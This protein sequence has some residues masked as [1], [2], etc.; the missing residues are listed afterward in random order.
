[1]YKVVYYMTAGTLTSKLF[2][3][4]SEAL[5]FSVYSVKSGNV[6]EIYKVD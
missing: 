4:L 1:M 2:D 6:Y 5:V 3:T